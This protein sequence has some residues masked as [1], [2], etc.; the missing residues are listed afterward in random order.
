MSAESF[1]QGATTSTASRAEEMF[2]RANAQSEAIKNGR[3][4]SYGSEDFGSM[5]AHGEYA[6]ATEGKSEDVLTGN[7]SEHVDVEEVVVNE[8]E[9]LKQKINE[10]KKNG[11]IEDAEFREVSENEAEKISMEVAPDDSMEKK[12]EDPLEAALK[13]ARELYANTDY[14][15]RTAT[16]RIRKILNMRSEEKYKETENTIAARNIYEKALQDLKNDRLAKLKESGLT[17]KELEKGMKD[18]FT[19]FN[20][21]ETLEFYDAKTK[22]KLEYL[23]EEENKSKGKQIWD[24][25]RLASGKIAEAYNKKVPVWAKLG[26]AGLALVP[27]MQTFAVGKRAWGAFMMASV[28]GMSIDK[29]AQFTDRLM[30]EKQGSKAVNEAKVENAEE[31]REIDFDK[32]DEMLNSKIAELDLKLD[33][34]VMRSHI[35]KFVAVGSAFFLGAS[36]VARIAEAAEHGAAGGFLGKIFAHKVENAN[37]VNVGTSYDPSKIDPR[38]AVKG[39]GSVGGAAPAGGIGPDAANAG[40]TPS[41]NAFEHAN[42]ASFVPSTNAYEHGMAQGAHSAFAPST[43]A[44]EHAPAAPTQVGLTKETM[45]VHKGSNFIATLKKEYLAKHH[46]ELIKLNPKLAGLSDD[47]IAFRI[48]KAY[49][50]KHLDG[51]LPDLVKAGAKMTFDPKTMEV[52]F[53]KPGMAGYYPDVAD[54]G[55]VDATDMPEGVKPAD[56]PS[57]GTKASMEEIAKKAVAEHQAAELAAKQEVVN[58]TTDQFAQAHTDY[59]KAAHEATVHPAGDGPSLNQ[60]E[61]MG[62]ADK[63]MQQSAEYIKEHTDF[64]PETA[65]QTVRMQLAIVSNDKGLWDEIQN[66]EYDRAVSDKVIGSK[67]ELIKQQ[68]EKEFGRRHAFTPKDGETLRKWTMRVSNAI[69]EKRYKIAA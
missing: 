47:Q 28:G 67:L 14:R 9:Q 50:D 1:N 58:S 4:F 3:N 55:D 10:A 8:S 60:L 12:N 59:A 37:G 45:T 51:H 27:G 34:N 49:G 62:K 63:I 40:F 36:T 30:N 19:F 65:K 29:L 56:V 18:L 44:Y 7:Q 5:H 43:N 16:Q 22:A 23:A 41:T 57:G 25:C 6:E 11:D 38:Y 61:E 26:L 53:L 64:Y 54:A 21:K 52:H 39:V 32:F 68:F 17:G 66:W 15:D 69:M 48:A 31:G 24:K 2:R 42:K 46:D 33:K 13:S 20:H 35:N